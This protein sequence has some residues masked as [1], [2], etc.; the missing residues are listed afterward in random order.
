[1]LRL[2][3]GQ[4]IYRFPTLSEALEDQSCRKCIKGIKGQNIKIKSIDLFLGY[5]EKYVLGK[6]IPWI[7]RINVFEILLFENRASHV[8]ARPLTVGKLPLCSNWK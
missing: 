7:S 3:F 8:V 5:R 1:M 6:C 4:F 2:P